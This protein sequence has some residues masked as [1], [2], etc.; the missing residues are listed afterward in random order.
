LSEHSAKY[1]VGEI[2]D[3]FDYRGRFIIRGILVDAEIRDVRDMFGNGNYLR[4]QYAKIV[5]KEGARWY[6]AQEVKKITN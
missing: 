1:P 3:V 4:V 5:S 6:E 2:V